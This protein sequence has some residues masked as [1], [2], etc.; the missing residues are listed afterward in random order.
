M[1]W[2]F[3]IV[4]SSDLGLSTCPRRRCWS[5]SRSTASR[6]RRWRC[7]PR[8]AFLYIFDRITGKPIWPIV[9]KPVPQS[10]VPGEKTSK[11]QPFPTKPAPYARQAITDDDL[12]DFTPELHAKAQDIDQEVLQDG[13][14]VRARGGQQ[15]HRRL[16]IGVMISAALSAA[17][18]TG[19]APASIRKPI[20]CSRRP[21][22]PAS[23][24]IGLVPP[25]EGLSDL[26][27]LTKASAGQAFRIGG[28]P[29]FG[30][31]SDAPKV[32][33]DD[34]KLAAALAA[35]PQ[36][37]GRAAAAAQCRWPAAG[38]AALWHCS[39]RINLNTGD[40]ALAGAAWRHAG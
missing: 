19:R 37:V 12:I 39:P 24:M 29:G 17:A 5:T 4:A 16:P 2:Y 20:P 28:G 25:P 33:A 3:Q 1:K 38:Q 21:P 6:S 15:A 9:E 13:P 22:M 10:D 36:N 11:T 18:P 14:D 32:S 40:I 34:Q 7:R 35:H 23:S 30:S 27:Y 26:K 8:Q 31:A